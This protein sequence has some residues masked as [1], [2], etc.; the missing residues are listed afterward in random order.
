[1][2]TPGNYNLTFSKL[3]YIDFIYNGGSSLALTNSSVIN[4]STLTPCPQVNIA[5][6]LSGTL[7]NNNVYIITGDVTIPIGQSLIIQPGTVIKFDGHY[8]I[9]ASGTLTANGTPGNNIYFITN[10]LSIIWNAIVIETSSSSFSNCIFESFTYALYLYQC[11]PNITNNEFRKFGGNAITGSY[12]SSLISENWIHDFNLFFAAR[13]IDLH[14]GSAVVICNKIN[15]GTGN[16]MEISGNC[17]IKNNLIYNITG[18]R[19]NGIY[20]GPSSTDIFENNYLHDCNVGVLISAN[21]QPKPHPIITN[22]TITNMAVAG[23]QLNDLLATGDIINN[24]IV[25]NESG[26]SQISPNSCPP[27]AGGSC[28]TTPSVVSNNLVWNNTNGNYP[29]VQVMNIGMNTTTNAQGNPI[30][31][32][33]NMS[34]DPIF[35]QNQQPEL[36]SNSPCINAGDISFSSN[37]GF[38]YIYSCTSTT[39][40]SIFNPINNNYTA[41]IYPNPTSGKFKIESNSPGKKIIQI[42]EI[43]GKQILNIEVFGNTEIDLSSFDNG[44]YFVTIEENSF[45]INRKIILSN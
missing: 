45:K 2:I 24:I 32:Y 39:P 27:Q 28:A 44:V 19:G 37:I 3:E 36:S 25:N 33:N 18:F 23:I 26:I 34:L 30:D 17:T 15:D 29:G 10:S 8:S 40:L 5:G 31:Q 16:G 22:N 11:S 21:I 13:G 4:N 43:S 42:F 20:F 12:S 35:V 6:N 7:S 41:N 14:G 38:N 9:T 1:M